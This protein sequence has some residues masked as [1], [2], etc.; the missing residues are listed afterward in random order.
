MMS[1]MFVHSLLQQHADNDSAHRDCEN[2]S[3]NPGFSMH[4]GRER[5]LVN[6]LSA[7][8]PIHQHGIGDISMRETLNRSHASTLQTEGVHCQSE[9]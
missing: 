1:G 4:I 9:H 2:K 3:G 7:W 6:I 8:A 5:Q